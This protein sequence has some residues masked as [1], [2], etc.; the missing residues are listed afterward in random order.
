MRSQ[1]ERT[2]MGGRHAKL[3]FCHQLESHLVNSPV[4]QPGRLNFGYTN[5]WQCLKTDKN[6]TKVWVI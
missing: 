5:Y 4:F 1:A 3:S 6:K 2:E